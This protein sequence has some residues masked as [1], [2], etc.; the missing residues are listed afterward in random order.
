MDNTLSLNNSDINSMSKDPNIV[1]DRFRTKNAKQKNKNLIYAKDD[2]NIGKTKMQSIVTPNQRIINE[3]KSF[4]NVYP[5]LLPQTHIF[6]TISTIYKNTILNNKLIPSKSDYENYNNY[7]ENDKSKFLNKFFSNTESLNSYLQDEQNSGEFE[8]ILYSYPNTNFFMFLT[9]ELWYSNLR[10]FKNN[11]NLNIQELKYQVFKDVSRTTKITINNLVL[12]QSEFTPFI[13]NKMFYKGTDYLNLKIMNLVDREK[14]PIDLNTL[15]LIDILLIQQIVQQTSDSILSN[16]AKKN[17]FQG[18]E[19]GED[20]KVLEY[21]IVLTSSQK[22]I[23]FHNKTSLI[24]MTDIPKSG[25]FESWFKINLE[26]LQYSFKFIISLP[27]EL[28]EGQVTQGELTQDNQILQRY[29]N[30]I[31]NKAINLKNNIIDYAKNNP[32]SVASSV[33]AIS[34]LGSG[35]GTLLLAGILGGKTKKRFHKRFKQRK[36]YKNKKNIYKKK[37][38]KHKKL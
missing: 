15:N 38:K 14:I 9:K 4:V 32:A 17:I 7:K 5:E 8:T 37:T 18:G 27:P 24:T 29:T 35:V 22:Y 20:D 10:I 2:L 16:L 12:N 19:A 1:Q 28:T 36:T 23:Q 13:Q 6:K 21:E 26:S 31:K 34:V 3:Y 25:K 11:G 30:N 33:G